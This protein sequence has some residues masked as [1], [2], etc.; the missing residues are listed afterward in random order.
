[1]GKINFY[2]QLGKFL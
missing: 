1:M 2:N